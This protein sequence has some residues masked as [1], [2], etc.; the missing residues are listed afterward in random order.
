MLCLNLLQ[1]LSF[2]TEL[3]T[4]I[5]KKPG[6]YTHSHISL[7]LAD[8]QLQRSFLPALCEFL[9]KDISL[10]FFPRL[11]LVCVSSEPL[12]KV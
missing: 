7:I 5:W 9:A 6:I 3:I 12:S 10:I 4:Q 2:G 11:C 8:G 1:A